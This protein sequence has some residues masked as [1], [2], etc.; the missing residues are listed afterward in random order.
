MSTIFLIIA[1]SLGVVALGF[2][3]RFFFD[4]F[5]ALLTGLDLILQALFRHR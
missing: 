3:F 1:V 2:L 4:A 5:V